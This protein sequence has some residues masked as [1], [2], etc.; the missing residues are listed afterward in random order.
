MPVVILRSLLGR[1]G[2]AV[3][4]LVGLY[5]SGVVWM[6]DGYGNG[7][8]ALSAA[9]VVTVATWLLWWRPT[10]VLSERGMRVRNAWRSH[11]LP[12]PGVE[13]IQTRWGLVVQASGHRVQVS[14]C[15]RG[16]VLSAMRHERRA[17]RAR[18]EYLTP[19]SPGHSPR[20][21]RTHLDADDAA[22]LLG[23]YEAACVEH[24]RYR[25]RDGKEEAAVSRAAASS[26]AQG[27]R[28]AVPD[29]TSRWEP[30]PIVVVVLSVVAVLACF[31]VL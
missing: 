10:A 2:T 31:T 27:D 8:R 19:A 30:V 17:P 5:A 3:V 18:E 6:S 13:V 20:I 9:V 22:Y 12:W 24:Q 25:R 28:S 15:Q 7:L 29:P 16:G 11:T 21:Y 23:L 4:G 1:L 14:A 26:G